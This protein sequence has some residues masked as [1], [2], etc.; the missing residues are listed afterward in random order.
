MTPFIT[1]MIIG[2]TIIG[3][4]LGYAVHALMKAAKD[5]DAKMLVDG[6]NIFDMEEIHEN[7]TVQVLTNS[8]TGETSIGWWQNDKP[9]VNRRE[10]HEHEDEN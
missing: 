1:G 6:L 3:A 2:V 5:E 4:P 10:N 8:V 7:C 9:P